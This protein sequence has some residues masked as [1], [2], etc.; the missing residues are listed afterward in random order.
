MA[1][2]PKPGFASSSDGDWLM[3][4][5]RVVA[6]DGANFIVASVA[7][8]GTVVAARVRPDGTLLDPEGLW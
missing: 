3:E 8:L 6:F 7:D 5:R 1:K 2:S 4:G